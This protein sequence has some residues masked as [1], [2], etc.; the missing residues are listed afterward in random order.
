MAAALVPLQDVSEGVGGV[1]RGHEEVEGAPSARQMR[2]RRGQG[3][4]GGARRWT[5]WFAHL[6]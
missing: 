2:A 4:V 1:V 6:K 3:L 5:P